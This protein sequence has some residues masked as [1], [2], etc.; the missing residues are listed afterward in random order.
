MFGDLDRAKVKALKEYPALM[1]D[2]NYLEEAFLCQS[3]R[4]QE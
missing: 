2:E 1:L 4:S 3:K